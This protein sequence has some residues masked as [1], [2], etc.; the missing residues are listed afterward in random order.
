MFLVDEST[1]IEE[2][3]FEKELDFVRSII[4]K[5]AMEQSKVRAGLELFAST[6]RLISGITGDSKSLE[7][8]LNG[9]DQKFGNTRMV[10]ALEMAMM[11]LNKN[12]RKN[13]SKILL[14]VTDGLPTDNEYEM[15]EVIRQVKSHNII[16]FS[17]AVGTEYV[18]HYRNNQYLLYTII[19]FFFIRNL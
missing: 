4:P 19:Q 3:D 5:L 9:L 7:S 16:I 2:E 6:S 13:V 1:T 10:K 15:K 17:I 8:S 12:E 11:E 14:F 18:K